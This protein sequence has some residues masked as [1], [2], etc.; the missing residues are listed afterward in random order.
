MMRLLVGCGLGARESTKAFLR[1]LLAYE[2]LFAVARLG[3]RRFES[4]EPGLGLVVKFASRHDHHA[5]PRRDGAHDG[6][7]R[8]RDQCNDRW[9][10]ARR[11]A[12]AWAVVLVLKGAHTL[13]AAPDGRVSVLPFKTDALS[14][15]GTGDVLAGLI[16]GLRAQGL[17]AFDSARLGAYVH[18]SAGLLAGESVG[19]SRS[20]IASDVLSSIGRSFAACWSDIRMS[21]SGAISPSAW[22]LRGSLPFPFPQCRRRTA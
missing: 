22:L 6:P 21:R 4:D 20:V 16:A 12:E 13:V 11:Y 18:A 7:E 8:S 10:I 5:P 2:R 19:S 3:C 15:A 9:A 17:S 1:R 14:T